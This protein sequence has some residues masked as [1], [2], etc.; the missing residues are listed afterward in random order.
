[1]ITS[2]GVN[3]LSLSGVMLCILDELGNFCEVSPAWQQKLGCSSEFL[4]GR[5]C[6]SIIH[7]AD[8]P[9]T[10]Q[11]IKLLYQDIK[12]VH[13]SNRIRCKQLDYQWFV[14]EAKLCADSKHFYAVVQ[15]LVDVNST[16]HEE[17]RRYRKLFEKS[18]MGIL[19]SRQEGLPLAA[20]PA[21]EKMMGYDTN[22]LCTMHFGEFTYPEDLNVSLEHF[23]LLVEGK[24]DNYQL[25][26]RYIRKNGQ[27]IWCHVTVTR[28]STVSGEFQCLA[29]FQNI[30]KRKEIEKTLRE[31]EERFDLAMQ[32]ANDGIWDYN[33]LTNNVYYS[34]R[35]KTM[36]GYT[37]GEILS[38][39]DAIMQLIHPEDKEQTLAKLHDCLTGVSR[40][41]EAAYRLKHKNGHYRWIL[42][43]GTPI[44]DK[45]GQI[46]RMVGVHT[47][48][49][50]QKLAEQALQASKDFLDKVVN[51][52]PTPVFV[53]DQQHHWV[54]IND[55]FC[56]ML[57]HHKE[58]LLGKS[59]V[60]FF[61]EH[62]TQIF[63]QRDDEI[64]E[65]GETSIIETVL[66]TPTGPHTV[67]N[68]KALYTDA[69][70]KRFIVG[71]TI[72]ITDLKRN[73]IALLERDTILQAVANATR[74]LLTTKDYQAASQEALSII[75]QVSGADRVYIFENNLNYQ[76]RLVQSQRMEW[77][78]S[79]VKSQINNPELQN[80]PYDNFPNYWYD[81]LSQGRP[82]N[83][84][85]KDLP[86]EMN[87][88]LQAQQILAILIVPIYFQ[89]H[90]WGFIGLDNCHDESLWSD[91]HI[92]MLRVVGDSLR[93]VIARQY[94]EQ[95]LQEQLQ[96]NQTILNGSMDGFIIVDV[97]QII[98]EVNPAFC[99]MS[100][101]K[102]QELIGQPITFIDAK[103]A[104]EDITALIKSIKQAGGIRFETQLCHQQNHI[105]DVEVSSSYVEFEDG[106]QVLFNFARDIT[107]RKQATSEL[108]TAKESAQ[109]QLQRNQLILEG[110][111]DGFYVI[112]SDTYF[113]EVNPAFCQMLGYSRDELLNMTIDMLDTKMGSELSFELI[114]EMIDKGAI[115]FET[116]HWHKQD[117]PIDVEVSANFVQF[118]DEEW[119]FFS[120]VRDIRE[121]KRTTAEL[122]L[123]KETAELANSAKSN[124][125]ATMSHEIRTPMNGIIGIT[126]LLT[127]TQLDVQQIDYV[128]TVRKSGESL[129]TIINDILDF[130]KIEAN[131]LIL[132]VLDFDLRELVE[133]VLNLFAV[134]ADSQGT[135]LLYEMPSIAHKLIGD[136]GRIRQILTNLIGNAIKFTEKGEVLLR[137]SLKSQEANLDIMLLNFEIVDTGIGL[138]E[139]Q[140]QQ[141]FQPFSQA[142]TSTT[143]RYG[144]TGLGLVITQRLV[145]MMGG[146]IGVHSTFGE[147][148]TFWFNL[149]LKISANPRASLIGVEKLQ[150]LK[151][152]V[153]EDN[154]HNG[155]ILQNQAQGWGMTVSIVHTT[156]KAL[157]AL[158]I[159]AIQH[160]PYKIIVIDAQL[161]KTDVVEFIQ[162]LSHEY[163]ANHLAIILLTSLSKTLSQQQAL[164]NL[165]ACIT[166]PIT[167][168]GLLQALLKAIGQDD[169]QIV[170]EEKR[171]PLTTMPHRILLVEDNQTNQKV[172][173]IMLQKI[174][175]Q[176]IVAN[177]GIE[178]L[179]L[180]E[181]KQFDLIFM[182][183]QM[184]EMDGFEATHQI[185]Q[186]N[187]GNSTSIPIIALTAN[188]MEGDAER[189]LSVGM[190]A[191]LSKPV[192]LG[193]L[194]SVIKQWLSKSTVH[195]KLRS[196]NLG[197]EG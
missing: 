178:A 93:G 87:E 126:E 184:P 84:L 155:H 158:K 37:E 141:L 42:S 138:T 39:P 59:D 96:R 6:Q 104:Q 121:Q 123:A 79:N 194:E 120:F 160:K 30:S 61:P 14:W 143:R 86:L 66:T 180:F 13:F 179:Q 26:K 25:E 4:V 159:A 118:Q 106:E 191:Y 5:D 148:S 88:F 65:T 21:F 181:S 112:G 55:S 129:L 3:F 102:R 54:L 64:L 128:E 168:K 9:V 90:F 49:T 44:L 35:W 169:K 124:F 196:P 40:H 115:R 105:I 41:Y 27:M 11:T 113:K 122:Q 110:S 23:N 98:Q 103:L 109:Q 144:G 136:P 97:H 134:K 83:V 157:R 70:G 107:E 167:Q 127:S 187:K 140:Q 108:R 22:E 57:G 89:N 101:Y 46:H 92:F 28:T 7:A 78:T 186:K 188:A 32:G 56:D 99:Q 165:I 68:K 45:Q 85:A 24:I 62:E 139:K 176:V 117:Y 71:S 15:P 131:K 33:L 170:I 151:L 94:A 163:S 20:N 12:T 29:M 161:T 135:E 185:R 2:Y 48:I 31:R 189:C 142:D 58:E 63:W 60:D 19:F 172:A 76:G 137:I 10:E 1:M 72:D 81:E 91:N 154:L 171:Q 52:I 18:V 73:E 8:I 182:D 34:P 147:G 119:R 132:E 100:G 47:D 164:P 149:L 153:V 69:Q 162:I 36:L 43:R 17:A 197:I 173:T 166:K 156:D 133:E 146:N 38:T 53:K 114:S 75:G 150:G 116:Q 67:L 111:L 174:G 195:Q 51:A 130:S 145:G 190:N 193:D 192:K 183:C 95:E 77:S 74:N 175:C 80:L 16:I 152:L 82:L 177:N 50:E 125:L